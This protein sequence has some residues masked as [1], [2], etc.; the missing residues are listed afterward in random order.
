MLG[1]GFF[2]TA[3]LRLHTLA[4][5]LRA[6]RRSASAAASI[7]PNLT[8]VNALVIQHMQIGVLI[9]D[10]D[11]N[12]RLGNQAAQKFLGQALASGKLSPLTAVFARSPSSCSAGWAKD[13]AAATGAACSRRAPAIPSCSDSLRSAKDKSAGAL[14]FLGDMAVLKQQ[15]QQPKMASLAR[16]TASIA[17]EIRNPLGATGQC[18]QAAPGGGTAERS[19]KAPDQDH[20]RPEPAHE[21]DR[22]E[23]HQPQPA[24]PRKPGALRA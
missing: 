17:H 7:S 22:R 23:R 24:R 8:Q 21:R 5:R 13:R 12:I 20:R 10:A 9:C 2:V 16:L 6:S 14:I 4:E 18:A 3:F 11:G 1:I 15:A 19:G